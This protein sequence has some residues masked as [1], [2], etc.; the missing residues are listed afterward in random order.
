VLPVFLVLFLG[1]VALWLLMLKRYGL[2][3]STNPLPGDTTAAVT[4]PEAK[5]VG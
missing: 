5:L 3:G 4:E 1:G 2:F